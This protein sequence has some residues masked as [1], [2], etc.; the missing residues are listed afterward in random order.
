MQASA[1]V[2]L[3]SLPQIVI[4]ALQACD[5]E[6]DFSRLSTLIGRD[7]AL[8]ARVMSL[9]NS[10]YFPRHPRSTRLQEA[11][12]RLGT[13]RLRTLLLTAAMQQLMMQWHQ[14]WDHELRD[15]WRSTLTTAILAR[16]LARLTSSEDP[17]TAFLAGMLHNVGVLLSL[18]GDHSEALGENSHPE[19]GADMVRSWGLSDDVVEAIRYH[20]IDSAEISQ[21]A[22]LTRLLHVSRMLTEQ[23]DGAMAV[24]ESLFGL[25]LDLTRE[26]CRRAESD[27]ERIAHS[28]SV[29]LHGNI[30]CAPARDSLARECLHRLQAIDPRLVPEDVSE[31]V[32]NPERLKALLHEI[33]NPLSVIRNY[34]HGIQQRFEQQDPL[35]ERFNTLYEELD[36]ISHLLVQV[37]DLNAEE[38]CSEPLDLVEET[39]G[40]ILLLQES[41]LRPQGIECQLDLPP[42]P[43]RAQG[44]RGGLRQIQI[45]LVRNAAEAMR[46]GGRLRVCVRAPVWQA[47]QEWA[48]LSI[49]DTGPGLP[50]TIRKQLFQPVTSHKG[51]THQGLGLSIVRQLAD[52]LGAILSCVSSDQG[53]EFRLL[54]PAVE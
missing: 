23:D 4:Q 47:G 42:H 29:P 38:P 1:D 48:E 28:L 17:E 8:T 44:T 45:N 40:L 7:T 36:R 18:T 37:S 32:G 15:F 19:L 3:P 10:C 53:T 24:A 25:T 43:V 6:A 33:N 11:L 52:S 39:R 50:E 31:P 22:P 9:A 46:R 5:E 34:L 27:V 13:Y 2:A 41:L 49:A 30:N 26:L 51:Q 12:L 54:M 20:R 14:E 21:H 35:Q 16:A